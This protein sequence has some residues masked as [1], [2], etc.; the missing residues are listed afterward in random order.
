MDY[1]TVDDMYERG[2]PVQLTDRWTPG[3]ARYKSRRAVVIDIE[4]I[5]F[6]RDIS[7]QENGRTIT[8]KYDCIYTVVLMPENFALPAACDSTPVIRILSVD[9]EIALDA[10]GE[11]ADFAEWCKSE[12]CGAEPKPV[13]EPTPARQGSFLGG[14]IL[15]HTLPM[16]EAR[17]RPNDHRRKSLAAIEEVQRRLEEWDPDVMVLASTHWMPREGFFI[18]DGTLHQDG[19][20]ASYKGVEPQ[21]F[22][23]PGDPE[24]AGLAA[25]L[26]KEAGLPVRRLHRVAQEHA[27]WV[28]SHL[29]SGERRIPVVPCSIWWHGPREAHRKLGE[30]FAEAVRRL[31][32]KAFFVAS[33][34]LS[35]TFDF[36]K[37]PEYVVPAGERMDRLAVE[38]LEK[39]Q[40]G[41]LLDMSDEEFETWNP[42]GRAGHLYMLRGALGG[43]VRGEP[44]CYQGSNGT[45]YLT[46]V[47]QT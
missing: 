33:G 37:P 19:C 8:Q 47:F 29:L 27:V 9:I 17:H 42:E 38:W 45:G 13:H 36:S 4:V 16:F 18:D 34:G 7:R 5:G 31:G 20:D 23:F 22:G 28:P 2:A 41:R 6:P 10:K 12:F 44:L 14:V 24:L 32:R 43:D 15:P 11:L 35:H 21:L 3:L 1:R 25:Y 39:G 46:M 40:H 26:G 30:V